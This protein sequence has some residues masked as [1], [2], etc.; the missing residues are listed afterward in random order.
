MDNFIEWSDK[1]S[2]GVASMDE[3]HKCLISLMNQLYKLNISKAGKN[4]IRKSLTALGQYTQKHFSDEE[5]YM[6]S[7]KFSR[8]GTHKI[9]HTQLL[10]KLTDHVQKF[11]NGGDTL[12][13]DFF[14]FL[15]LWLTAHICQIDK[16]YGCGVSP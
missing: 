16:T 6:E 4:E 9:I 10:E 1:L 14:Q 8:L 5:A 11:E 7:I 13:D 12:S 15:K 2:T 3:E